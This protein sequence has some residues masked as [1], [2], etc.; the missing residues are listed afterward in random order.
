M[1]KTKLF[2]ASSPELENDRKELEVF[3]GR[4]NQEWVDRG[5]LLRA[6]SVGRLH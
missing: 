4:N 1:I 2:P 5:G 6:G 3:I